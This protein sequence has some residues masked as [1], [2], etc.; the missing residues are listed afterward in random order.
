[1]AHQYYTIVTFTIP[2][3]F[4]PNT[5]EGRYFGLELLS[6]ESASNKSVMASWV[7]ALAV[8]RVSE[9]SGGSIDFAEHSP[10]IHKIDNSDVFQR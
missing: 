1:M 9:Q 4:T 2:K 8:V 3:Y 7:T 10:P 6:V 5:D